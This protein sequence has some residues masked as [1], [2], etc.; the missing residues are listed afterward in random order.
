MHYFPRAATTK[1]HNLAVFKQE[2]F[3]FSHFWRPEVRKQGFVRATCLLEALDD[4]SLLL[5]SLWYLPAISEISWFL[6]L[7]PISTPL[8]Q[9][10]LPAFPS[11][12]KG[13]TDRIRA[14][15]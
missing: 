12:N 4:S 10:A 8:S 14:P 5:H 7:P 15:S 2:T 13:I 6:V 9:G 11:S 1:L 3:V